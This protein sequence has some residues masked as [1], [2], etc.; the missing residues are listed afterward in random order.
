MR[1][2]EQFKNRIQK[3]AG[4]PE[5]TPLK[6]T[7]PLSDPCPPEDCPEGWVWDPVTCH[8]V[9]TESDTGKCTDYPA[10]CCMFIQNLPNQ[11][12][13]DNEEEMS[14]TC[15]GITVAQEG[16]PGVTNLNLN[17]D[18][19]YISPYENVE[20]TLHPSNTTDQGCCFPLL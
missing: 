20:D 15:E 5:K 3:I 4:I 18:M 1:L 12:D 13:W 6:G 7:P 17:W 2:T 16:Y 9:P 10:E 19:D 8:C 11:S 14:A